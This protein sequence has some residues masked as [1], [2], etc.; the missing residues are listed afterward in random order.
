M[1]HDETVPSATS[2]SSTD[3]ILIN[4]AFAFAYMVVT[5]G[6][7]FCPLT[8]FFEP[9]APLFQPANRL[10]NALL[11]LTFAQGRVWRRRRGEFWMDEVSRI[12]FAMATAVALLMA[13]TYFF[14]SEAP[15]S[16]RLM[17]FWALLFIVVF[18]G[19][20]RL[21]RRWGLGWLYRHGRLVDNAVV[22]GSGE[23][24]RGVIRTVLA[25]PELGYHLVGYLDDGTGENSIGSGRVPHLGSYNDLQ[26]VLDAHPDLHTVFMALPGEMHS[27]PWPCCAWPTPPTR[28]RRLCPICCSSA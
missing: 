24:G 2:P 26:A 20:A 11:I 3:L 10:L 5:A 27:K 6:N 23:V 9:Y 15:F 17:L 22:V 25:R 8:N 21:L 16:S 28:R 7:G 19:L 14:L 12:G 1:N 13:V 4:G 18:I